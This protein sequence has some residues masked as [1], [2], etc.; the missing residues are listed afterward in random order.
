MNRIL[1][2]FC[3]ILKFVRFYIE[4]PFQIT[5]VDEHAIY[6]RPIQPRPEVREVAENQSPSDEMRRWLLEG[7][8]NNKEKS[9]T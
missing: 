3:Q 8:K 2:N 6:L 5:R 9:F 4:M 7:H 1:G